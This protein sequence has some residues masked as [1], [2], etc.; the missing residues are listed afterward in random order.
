MKCYK[1]GGRESER[2]CSR[3]KGEIRNNIDTG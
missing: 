2:D 3:N 1:E